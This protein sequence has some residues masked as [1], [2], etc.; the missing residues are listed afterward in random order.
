MQ[1]E[2]IFLKKSDVSF[3]LSCSTNFNKK[4]P[5]CA[6]EFHRVFFVDIIF[7]ISFLK[8]SSQLVK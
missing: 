5:E 3:P 2:I 8:V 1:L 4:K 6:K 7:D